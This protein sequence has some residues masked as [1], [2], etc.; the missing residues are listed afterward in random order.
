LKHLES[1]TG[2]NYKF[3]DLN[4]RFC[5]DFRDYLLH[6]TSLSNNSASSYFDKFKIAVRDAY[7]N[8]MLSE[9]PAESIKSIKLQ[10][11]EREFL[12][13]EELQKLAETRFEYDDLRRASLFSALTGLRYSD[14]A[15]LTW[16][17]I[18]QSDTSGYFIA[19][20]KRKQKVGNITDL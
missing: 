11:T 19:S 10:D 16:K 13:L 6:K 14:I 15:K 3:G 12:T 17:E 2:G 8:K 18:Q 20:R 5:L 7:K 4:E 9:N 1:F